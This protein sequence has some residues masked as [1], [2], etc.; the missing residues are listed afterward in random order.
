[1][2]KENQKASGENFGKGT[3]KSAEPIK[4]TD[5]R[6]EIAKL[7]GVSHIENNMKVVK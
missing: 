1:M 2:A 3:Q 5:T 6:K 4:Q 7:A